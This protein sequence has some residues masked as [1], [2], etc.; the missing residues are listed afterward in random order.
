[1]RNIDLIFSLIFISKLSSQS[2]NVK[3]LDSVSGT[4]IPF[5]TIYFSSNKGIIS[6]EGGQFELILKEYLD[7][8]TNR[9]VSF[10]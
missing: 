8:R 6:D 4:P 2:N 5:A 7:Y 10:I 3:V 1:M 9:S